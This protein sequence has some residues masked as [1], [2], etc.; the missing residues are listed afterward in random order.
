MTSHQ[1]WLCKILAGKRQK[2]KIQIPQHFWSMCFTTYSSKFSK[3][4]LW[5]FKKCFLT[6][7]WTQKSRFQDSRIMKEVPGHVFC[8]A[9]GFHGLQ[10]GRGLSARPDFRS[11]FSLHALITD[12]S[13][14]FFFPVNLHIWCQHPGVAKGEALTACSSPSGFLSGWISLPPLSQADSSGSVY[15]IRWNFYLCILIACI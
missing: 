5:V 14:F 12:W 7:S 11:C 3:S 4:I 9:T 10:L 15:S 6:I 8:F 13:G 1:R 2:K